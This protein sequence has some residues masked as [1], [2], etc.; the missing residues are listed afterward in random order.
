MFT[1]PIPKIDW[2]RRFAKRKRAKTIPVLHSAMRISLLLEVSCIF[3][4]QFPRTTLRAGG[5]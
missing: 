5:L 1:A 2:K 4:Q 3:V